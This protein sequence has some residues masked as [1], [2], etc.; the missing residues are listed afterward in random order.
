MILKE[1]RQDLGICLSQLFSDLKNGRKFL[2]VY[3]QLKMYNDP[4]FNP[5]L[6]NKSN[7]LQ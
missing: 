4:D 2:K 3:R 7:E 5:V 1:Q 6:Y